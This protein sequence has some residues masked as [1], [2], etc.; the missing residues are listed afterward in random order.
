MDLQKTC[1]SELLSQL[2]DLLDT[3]SVP[4]PYE[5]SLKCQYRR[6]TI[7]NEVLGS[8][9]VDS[10]EEI[11][12]MILRAMRMRQRYMNQVLVLGH[13]ACCM[14][15]KNLMQWTLIE[16]AKLSALFGSGS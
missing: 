9:S 5:A 2:L 6:L 8:V 14:S 7:G 1:T 3:P 15:E 10:T 4:T 13:P 11:S 16:P 12:I